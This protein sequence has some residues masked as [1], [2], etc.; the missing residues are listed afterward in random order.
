M[1]ERSLGERVGGVDNLYAWGDNQLVKLF[2]NE[3]PARWVEHM[4][5]IDRALYAAGLPVPAAGESVE[6][7]GRLGLIY[8]R[9]D[10]DP[11]ADDLLGPRLADPDTIVQLARVFAQVHAEIHACGSIPGLPSQKK[12]LQT[13][14]RR[15]AVLPPDLKEGTLKALDEMPAGDRLCHGDFHPYNVLMSPRGPI[16]IDWNNAHIGNPLEDVARSTLILSGM[17]MS[18]PSSSSSIGRFTKAY[19]ERYD[20]LRPC[21]QQELAAWQ[22][23]VAA[24]RLRD[25]IPEL[26]EWLLAQIRTGLGLCD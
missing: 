6:I 22:P 4:S 3:A 23:I 25:N 14:I 17:S 2:G 8:E 21:D 9:I 19:L 16:V 5:R 26:Q 10:G 15:I 13:V 1:S 18:E 7:D 12:A 24:V 20:Q 11:M